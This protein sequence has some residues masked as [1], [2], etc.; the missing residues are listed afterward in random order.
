MKPLLKITA[1]AVVV[2]IVF[3]FN[4]KK[5]ES[6]ET[7]SNLNRIDLENVLAKQKFECRPSADFVFNVETII[8]KKIR[9]ANNIH[10][11]I[12]IV[13]KTTGRK[14]LLAQENILVKNFRDAI[15]IKDHSSNNYKLNLKVTE[16]ANGDKL[17]G[18]P[19]EA[20]YTFE[21][22]IQY[23]LIYNKYIHSTNKLLQL[24]RAI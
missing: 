16:L 8:L 20:P 11:K 19:N 12:F 24:K 5:N 7:N 9:G 15:G 1:I 6:F 17:L 2:I 3:A 4:T 23:D 14:S 18:K 10:A 22:L 13:D 21:K